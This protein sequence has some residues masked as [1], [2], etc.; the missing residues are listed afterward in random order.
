[1]GIGTIMLIG[2]VFALLGVLIVCER[3]RYNMI[4]H[5]SEPSDPTKRPDTDH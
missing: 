5:W 4:R 3:V 1:M 2:T